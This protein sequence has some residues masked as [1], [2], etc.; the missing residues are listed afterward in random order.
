MNFNSNRWLNSVKKK[1]FTNKALVSVWACC[2]RA[3]AA[4]AGKRFFFLIAAVEF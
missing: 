3:G 4:I 1:N 2:V